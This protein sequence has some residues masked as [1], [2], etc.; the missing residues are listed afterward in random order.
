MIF[1]FI[2]P[3]CLYSL[4]CAPLRVASGN[5]CWRENREAR[6]ICAMADC[7]QEVKVDSIC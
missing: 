5:E 4:E 1:V 6:A 3:E 2:S 7:Q